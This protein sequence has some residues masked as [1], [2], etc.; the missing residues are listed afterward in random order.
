MSTAT[1]KSSRDLL[2]QAF[3]PL[4]D[5]P[6]EVHSFAVEQVPGQAAYEVFLGHLVV[7]LS[8]EHLED[9]VARESLGNWSLG[10]IRR[11]RSG[12]NAEPPRFSRF[13][14]LSAMNAT[15]VDLL[16]TALGEKIARNVLADIESR[17]REEFGLRGAVQE[18]TPG[19]VA[20]ENKLLKGHLVRCITP[21]KKV[22]GSSQ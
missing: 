17:V 1:V 3:T 21:A 10:M 12:K 7:S 14:V 22:N 16:E 20:Y 8:F 13:E 4:L 18:R 5:G 19:M 15:L 2:V 6:E 9:L 11:L